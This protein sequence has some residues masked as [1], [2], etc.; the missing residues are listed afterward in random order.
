MNLRL[1]AYICAALTAAVLGGCDS[2]TGT[3]T[4]A[5][6]PHTTST[7]TTTTT[8]TATTQPGTGK[9]T[10]MIGDKNYTEQFVLGELYYEALQ[11]QGFSVQIDQNIGPPGVTM[12]ALA[13]GQLGMYPEYLNIW[14]AQIAG[15]THQFKTRHAAYIAGNRYALTHGLELL[16]PTPFSDTSAIGVTDNFAKQN[17]LRTIGDLSKVE[18]LLTIGGPPQFQ[19][20]TAAGLPTLE[21]VY[22]VIPA[23][24]KSLEIGQQ[25]KA[26]D[27]DAV[28]AADVNT[29]DGELTSGNYTLLGDPR[30]VFGIG[31]V[32]PVVSSE[33]LDKEGPAFEDT[34]NKVSALLTLPAIRALNAA[35]DLGGEAPA[36]V[37]ERFLVDHGLIPPSS[38]VI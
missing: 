6:P 35:V 3:V 34:V 9:P 37:A 16:N 22:G 25:Y 5:P 31:N 19:Q 2:S 30:H 10:V 27:Q 14:D 26:L 18:S 12:Q 33:T 13:S 17:N 28:Q 8:T 20:E 38:S 36:N 23:G 4:A 29:T 1:L 15:D 21:Q 11:A 32:V 24:F 7:Q